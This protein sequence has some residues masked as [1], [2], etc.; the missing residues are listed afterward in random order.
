[1]VYESSDRRTSTYWARIALL[2][3]VREVNPHVLNELLELVPLFREAKPELQ[4]NH[5]LAMNLWE[6][7]I[8][9]TKRPDAS[10]LEL[11]TSITAWAKTYNIN[12]DWAIK[13]AI[14]TLIHW[15]VD[16]NLFEY[17][18]CYEGHSTTRLAEEERRLVFEL[19]DGWET[20]RES[21]EVFTERAKESF[22]QSLLTY[23]TR[24][25]SLLNERQHVKMKAKYK[26]L[27]VGYDD[28]KLLAFRLVRKLA[29]AQIAD[30]LAKA[31]QKLE[32]ESD[33]EAS[34]NEDVIKN[35]VLR[36]AKLC[37]ID[38]K[39]MNKPG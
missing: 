11:R 31:Q 15:D 21:Q 1:M 36:T 38:M 20:D 12:F 33:S 25:K 22:K 28:F 39:T 4:R 27:V 19:E 9:K 24:I 13:H 8:M 35:R 5:P 18:W 23:V 10:I 34:V 16:M 2:E 30:I 3:A 37:G 32:P 14:Y 29:N 7:S 26:P 17:G 6:W